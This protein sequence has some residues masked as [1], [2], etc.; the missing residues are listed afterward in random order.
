MGWSLKKWLGSGS[1]GTSSGTVK[2]AGPK[3]I[4]DAVGR[5]MVVNLSQDPDWVWELKSVALPVENQKKVFRI[6]VFSPPAAAEKGVT[7]RDF[8]SLDAHPDL[9]VCAGILDKSAGAFSPD[10]A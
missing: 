6:R 1:G 3:E 9:I 7:V 10:A 2:A 4:P 5:Y 8:G